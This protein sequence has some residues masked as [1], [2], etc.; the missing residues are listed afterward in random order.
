MNNPKFFLVLGP[1]GFS[2]L[3]IS[4]RHHR[5]VKKVGQSDSQLVCF[6][7]LLYK[8]SCMSYVDNSFLCCRDQQLIVVYQSVVEN[9]GLERF[10][11]K[12]I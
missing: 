1:L 12:T 8:F 11:Y 4:C 7:Y 2:L 6:M 3:Q 10:V 9:T 5:R